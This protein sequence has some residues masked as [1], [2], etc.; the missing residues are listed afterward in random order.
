MNNL[1]NC[2]KCNL[3]HVYEDGVLLVCPECAY[4]WDPAEVAKQEKLVQYVDANGNQLASMGIQ[5]PL[6]KDLK[7]KGAL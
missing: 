5:L 3:Y 4:E 7:V 2:P 6:I 1:P